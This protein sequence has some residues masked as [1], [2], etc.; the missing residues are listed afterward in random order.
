MISSFS[1]EYNFLSNFYIKDI[2]ISD[3]V[4][5]SAEHMYQSL[6]TVDIS[7]VEAIMAAETPG[8]AKRLGNKCTLRPDWNDKRIAIMHE[9]VYCKFSLDSEL[10]EKLL[11]TGTQAL[12][13]GNHW[14]DTFWG[15]DEQG[16][17]ENWLGV[18]LQLVRS[19]LVS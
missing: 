7:E 13:E 9:V 14:G 17:G 8:R 1:G 15:V 11:A 2:N 12:Q 4:F 5:K 3:M 19:Q 6:K 10:K 18:I 16:N